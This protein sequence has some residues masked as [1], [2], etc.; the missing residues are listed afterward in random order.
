MFTENI[1][2][3]NLYNKY[4]P[5]FDEIYD[6]FVLKVKENKKI[7]NEKIKA[8]KDESKVIIIDTINEK[9]NQILSQSELTKDDNSPNN[10][11]N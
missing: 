6:K 7:V 9:D 10:N 2:K 4:I 1:Q 5:K 8:G 3:N 11:T